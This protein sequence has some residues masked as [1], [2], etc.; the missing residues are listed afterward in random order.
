M[1]M[2]GS[3][4]KVAI[5]GRN[6]AEPGN[7]LGQTRTNQLSHFGS[8]FSAGAAQ[9]LVTILGRKTMQ[10]AITAIAVTAGLVFSLAVA[11]LVEE[12]IFGQ[13]FRLF[14]QQTARLKAGQRR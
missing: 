8:R 1:L 12:L 11:L 9:R 6:I 5:G 14:A 7:M 13:V 3:M 10:L 2:W 4:S